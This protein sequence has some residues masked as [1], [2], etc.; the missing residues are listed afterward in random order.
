MSE[1]NRAVGCSDKL[2]DEFVVLGM[3][4]DPEPVHSSLHGNA[5]ST[6]V[7]S[8]TDAMELSAANGLELQRRM[9]RV[10][11]QQSVVSTRE[12]LDLS[13][14]CFKALPKPLRGRVLQGS[15]REPDR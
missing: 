5:E 14:Q 1:A 13:W 9:R 4:A 10:G 8:H 12:K 6:V 11:S 3:R 7:E 15:R 2:A